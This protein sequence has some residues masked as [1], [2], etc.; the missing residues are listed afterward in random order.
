MSDEVDS[1][2]NIHSVVFSKSNRTFS[3]LIYLNTRHYLSVTFMYGSPVIQRK[4]G[5]VSIIS[6]YVNKIKSA[7][8]RPLSTTVR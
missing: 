2:Q 6:A 7:L 5:S 3:W 1:P 4:M 8:Q